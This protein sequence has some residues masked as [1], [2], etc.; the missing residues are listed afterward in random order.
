MKKR[1]IVLFLALLMLAQ[2]SSACAE[3]APLLYRVTDDAGHV[4]YLLGTIHVGDEATDD[5][6]PA[7]ESAY[8]A[9]DVLAVEVDVLSFARNWRDLFKM[10]ALMVYRPGDDITK[11]FSPETCALGMEKLGVPP[12]ILRQMKPIAWYSLADQY[13]MDAV[14][15]SADRGVDMRLLS[16]AKRDGKPVHEMEGMDSQLETLLSFPESVMD[17]EVREML[18]H[19]EESAQATRMLYDAWRTGDEETLNALVSAMNPADGD[20]LQADYAAFEDVLIGSRNDG[21]TRQA[22]EYL[23][24][25]ETALIAI[26]AFHIVGESGLARQLALAGCQVEEIGR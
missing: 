22:M 3:C 11:H 2:A 7:V 12:F 16:R 6:G 14:G 19:P 13:V 23:S 4:I 5:L 17:A 18:L 21:F 26:G 1:L 8:A 24:R 9:A 15:L 10:A 25:G 20:A